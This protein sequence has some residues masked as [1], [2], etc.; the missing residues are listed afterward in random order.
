MAEYGYTS[1]GSS[2]AT[3]SAD[4]PFGSKIS[5]PGPV[6]ITKLWGY[7]AANT[8]TVN[9]K[10]AVYDSDGASEGPGTL[11]YVT[12]GQA[13]G[14]SPQWQSYDCSLAVSG[15]I[16]LLQ[17]PDDVAVFYYDSSTTEGTRLSGVTAI[18]G[19]YDS[20]DDPFPVSYTLKTNLYSQY[21]ETGS[22]GELSGDAG[23]GITSSG[24][25]TVQGALSGNTTIGVAV[26]GTM[27][28]HPQLSGNTLLGITA[29]GSMQ[30]H[31]QLSGNTAIVI[32]ASGEINQ[33]FEPEVTG[34]VRIG[35]IVAGRMQ[36]VG[37]TQ[38]ALEDGFIDFSVNTTDQFGETYRKEGRFAPEM[39]A[40]SEMSMAQKDAVKDFFIKVRATD[41]V[42][43]FNESNLSTY[44]SLIVFGLC[45][46]SKFKMAS[47]AD[48][49]DK[50]RVKCSIRIE[51]AV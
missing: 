33:P 43:D 28:T 1:A 40:I 37:T 32:A 50:A 23:I 47:R 14:T 17:I 9:F 51:G 35:K 44:T 12:E 22:G 36:D 16:W 20:P 18:V 21:V 2:P 7:R 25:I 38:W 24:E 8:G 49:L 10:I 11:L 34:T 5:I 26:S 3:F 46:E 42:W 27:Q 29:S 39:K 6:T 15:D 48:T 30:E 31:P 19:F 45:K 13:C 4:Q 41:C